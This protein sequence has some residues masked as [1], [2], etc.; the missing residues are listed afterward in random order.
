MPQSCLLEWAWNF[1][2]KK[3]T[4]DA[5]HAVLAAQLLAAHC[6]PDPTFPRAS[7]RSIYYDT[8]D[9]QFLT[10]KIDSTYLKAKSPAALVR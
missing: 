4:L 5:S 7:V 1:G 9:L 6:L 10:E 3:Y 2:P 8:L